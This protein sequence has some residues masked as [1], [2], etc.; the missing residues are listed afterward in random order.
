MSL[1]GPHS[2]SL[3]VVGRKHILAQ[4]GPEIW[5]LSLLARRQ[6]LY[7][8]LR[9]LPLWFPIYILYA[10]LR[11]PIVKHGYGWIS[12]RKDP[13]NASEKKKHVTGIAQ[14]ILLS[15]SRKTG[16]LGSIP[17]KGIDFSLLHS[18]QGRCWGPTEPPIQWEYVPFSARESIGRETD[19]TLTSIHGR[20]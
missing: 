4:C 5:S 9:I 16:E 6:A 15:A 13:Q 1:G 19:H 8:P 7:L 18:F 12:K 3:D 14:S 20:G 2:R 17:S 11:S 10:S